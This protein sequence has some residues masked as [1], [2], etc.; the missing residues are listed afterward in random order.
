MQM[1]APDRQGK[2][3]ENMGSER[4]QHMV[5]QPRAAAAEKRCNKQ[6]AFASSILLW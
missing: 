3:W 6:R 1:M 5:E 4:T 2:R